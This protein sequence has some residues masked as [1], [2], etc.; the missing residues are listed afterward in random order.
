M[1]EVVKGKQ[2]AEAAVRR[3]EE[4][5]S[6]EDRQSGWRYLLVEESGLKPGM[7]PQ[8]ATQRRQMDLETRELRA[9][10]QLDS[11]TARRR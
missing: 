5:Q 10:A 8:E 1:V 11:D 4:G 9:P 6:S 3:F 7:D 2:N